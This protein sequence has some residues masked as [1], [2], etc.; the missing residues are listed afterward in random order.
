MLIA[1]F[2]CNSVRARLGIVLDWLAAHKPDVLALQET[3][4]VDEQ[5]PVEA[6]EEAGWRVVSEGAVSVA[7]GQWECCHTLLNLQIEKSRISE[8]VR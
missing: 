1:T 5:F 4:C 3:K 7:N 2:N 8:D 6:F